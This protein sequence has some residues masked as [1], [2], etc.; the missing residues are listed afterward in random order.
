MKNIINQNCDCWRPSTTGHR[1][2]H[3]WIGS[4]PFNVLLSSWIH[5]Y[6]ACLLSF[7]GYSKRYI[8]IYESAWF[9][10]AQNKPLPYQLSKC[11]IQL[12]LMRPSRTISGPPGYLSQCPYCQRNYLLAINV[13]TNSILW[14]ASWRLCAW[15][16]ALWIHLR[17]GCTIS[18]TNLWW[19]DNFN[20]AWL[21]SVRIGYNARV[22]FCPYTSKTGDVRSHR[23]PTWNIYHWNFLRSRKQYIMHFRRI[24]HDQLLITW[25]MYSA[26]K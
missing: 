18:N 10:L 17:K 22:M 4:C 12:N 11:H 20:S 9:A 24:C 8:Y 5:W 1:R 3:W 15:L 25:A 16:S 14:D 19:L 26:S 13:K 7:V 21:K 2:V 6:R 23:G